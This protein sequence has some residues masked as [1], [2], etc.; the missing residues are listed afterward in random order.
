MFF[1]IAHEIINKLLITV[2]KYVYISDIDKYNILNMI[3][4]IIFRG[5][6]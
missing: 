6:D 3:S 5:D 1:Y 4:V 2:C